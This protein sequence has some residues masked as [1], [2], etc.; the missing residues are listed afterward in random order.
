MTA[1]LKSSIIMFI[2][3]AIQ[4]APQLLESGQRI[5]RILNK[6]GDPTP[7]EQAEL[8][9]NQELIYQ[10]VKDAATKKLAE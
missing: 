3:L 2:N 10:A 7:E 1:E 4:L 6:G 5:A 8:D 9:A